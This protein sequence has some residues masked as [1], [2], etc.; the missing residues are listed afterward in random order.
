[1]GWRAAIMVP[2]PAR[3]EGLRSRS[4]ECVMDLNPVDGSSADRIRRRWLWALPAVFVITRVAMAFLAGVPRH[5]T[6]SGLPITPDV[7]L[8]RGW[9]LQIVSLGREAYRQVP[10]E[11]P[12]GLLPFILLPAWLLRVADLAY[13]PTF[14]SLMVVVDTLGLI[15]LWRLSKRWG[16]MVGPWLWVFALPLLGPVAYLRLDLVPA[17]ATIWCLERAAAATWGSAGAFLGYGILAKVYPA[18]FIPATIAISPSRRRLTFGALAIIAVGLI[19]F[20]ASLGSMA[21]SVASYHFHRGIEIESLWGNALLLA[22]LAGYRVMVLKAFGSWEIHAGIAPILEF[23]SSTLSLAAV[24]YAGW[25]ALRSAR[26]DSGYLAWTWLALLAVLLITGRVLSP[27]YLIWLVALG[28]AVG[29]LRDMLP[30]HTVPLLMGTALLTQ[31]EFPFHVSGLVSADPTSIVV[32]TA[33]NL[34]LM[35]LAASS[36][37]M[38]LRMG[39]RDARSIRHVHMA[40][41]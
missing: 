8:Y 4:C 6:G 37:R 22:H 2:L 9:G 25:R 1:V 38:C 32:L 14:V 12:P 17:V 24:A 41:P 34:C 3:R 10:I 20:A 29:C 13:L 19:P 27:Q 30:W 7:Y 31:V 18:F 11:Y 35:A 26:R 33:R 15:G 28:A 36:M 39:E 5:Y 16:S 40:I 21:H 23:V